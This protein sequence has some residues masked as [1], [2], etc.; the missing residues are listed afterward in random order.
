MFTQA[1]TEPPEALGWLSW[2]RDFEGE[3]SPTHLRYLPDFWLPTFLWPGMETPGVFLEIKPLL[4]KGDA[5]AGARCA[6]LSLLTGAP[7]LRTEGLPL[8]PM[9]G[10]NFRNGGVSYDGSD[11]DAGNVFVYHARDSRIYRRFVMCSDCGGI[12]IEGGGDCTIMATCP[13]TFLADEWRLH[14]AARVAR[15]ARFEHGEFG[16]RESWGRRRQRLPPVS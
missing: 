12:A 7:V 15:A 5:I 11:A 6:L 3:L 13:G 14:T 8:A 2:V 10:L 1:L 16:Y 9:E 4:P